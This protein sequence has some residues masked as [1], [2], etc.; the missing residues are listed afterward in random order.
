MTQKVIGG[1]S[2]ENFGKFQEIYLKGKKIQGFSFN[3]ITGRQQV[4][5]S[6]PGHARTLLGF[7]FAVNNVGPGGLPPANN[8]LLWLSLNNDIIIN[9]AAMLLMT[10]LGVAANVLDTEFYKYTR[11][12]NGNDSIIITT[13]NPV[14]DTFGTV[15]NVYYS[16]K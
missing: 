12:L 8:T 10:S 3:M 16:E 6:M 13:D 9:A 1:P 15:V 4:Q 11:P 7:N 14:A 2:L 5:F